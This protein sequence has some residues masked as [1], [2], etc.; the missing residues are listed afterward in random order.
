MKILIPL[1]L[2]FNVMLYANATMS[3]KSYN[4]LME[5]QKHI[6]ENKIKEAKE[7]LNQLLEAKNDYAK[8]YAYQYLA[9]ITLQDNNYEK[10][11]E[12]YEIIIGLNALEKERIDQIKLSLSKI[13]LSLEKYTK[14]IKLSNELLKDS[15]IAKIDIYE[16]FIFTYYYTKDFKKAILYSNKYNTVS[17]EKKEN[18]YQILYSSYVELKEYT[19]AIA[20]LE[21]MTR[22][23]YTKKN[24]WLQLASLYQEKKQYKKALSTIELSYKKDILEPKKHTLFYVNLLF[25]NELYQKASM[26]LETAFKE[27]YIKEDKKTSELLI[28]SYLNAKEFDKAINKIAN[29]KMKKNPKYQKIL[30]NLY[31]RKHEYQ[32]TIDILSHSTK[33][34]VKNID[35]ELHILMALS[36]F[37][38]NKINSSIEH[39]KKVYHSKKRKRAISIAKALRIDLQD[40]K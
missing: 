10:T 4:I 1:L 24:Y 16:T 27:K 26:T 17:K 13:Y 22:Q 3:P 2:V 7:L 14:S 20:A 35:A 12:Y 5:A 9:N 6:E 36:Y 30:A 15:K 39:L 31:Y 38:L 34:K 40:L 25:Q 11:A 23:W 28:S 32:N 33:K 8:S 19:N 21:I 37:E 29:T 18:I